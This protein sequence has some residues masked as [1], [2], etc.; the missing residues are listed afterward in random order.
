MRSEPVI[1]KVIAVC[2]V[3]VALLNGSM[4]YEIVVLGI[5]PEE[6]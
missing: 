6:K 2:V 4:P 5:Y 1:A 3:V